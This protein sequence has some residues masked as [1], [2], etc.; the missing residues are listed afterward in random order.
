MAEQFINTFQN[1]MNSDYHVTLQPDGT[2]RFASNCQLIS[3]DGNNYVIKDTLGNVLT[4][5]INIRYGASQSL[6]DT[7]P[8]P[9][10]FI[11]LP[12]KLII[13]S[14]NNETAEGGCG[15]IGMIKYTTYGQGVMPI[16]EVGQMNSGYVP[17]YHSN[18]L[19]FSKLYRIEGFGIKENETI[20]RIYWT[21]NFNEPRTLNVLDPILSDYLPNTYTFDNNKTYMVLDGVIEFPI[22]SGDLYAPTNG[23]GTISGNIFGNNF[24]TGYTA[25]TGTSP[26]PKVILNIP[27]TLLSW[28]PDRLLSNIQISYN[29]VGNVYCGNKVYFYR[30]G[31]N[32]GYQTG[33]SY[34]SAP[35][36]V[37][38]NSQFSTGYAYHDYVG[39]GN[40]NELVSS[41]KS[42]FIKIDVIDTN[43]DYI[44]LACAEFDNNYGVMRAASIVDKKTITSDFPITL[45]HNGSTNLGNL[46]LNDL[47]LLPITLKTVKTLSTNKNFMLVGNIKEQDQ[48]TFDISGVTISSFNYPMPLMHNVTACAN[49]L[50]YNPQTPVFGNPTAGN[51]APN[52]RWLVTLGEATTNTVSYNGTLYLTGQV[53]T[54]INS[55]AGIN[56]QNTITFAGT[57][58]VQP[59]VTKNRYTPIGTSQ[60]REN[61]IPLIGDTLFWDYKSATVEYYLMI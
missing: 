19:K 23:T 13:F 54:G 10:G 31:L 2:Y 12:D 58:S 22:S 38:T 61:A 49:T 45:Q 25:I 27:V 29:S 32:S 8:M 57:G 33:W 59:C 41:G 11:S 4:F 55:G 20:E 17:L 43:Y 48:L 9:I 16:S 37:G 53:I 56:A 35:V 42:V 34:P 14:T 52:S 6:F 3:Q 28:S 7:P 26:T 51:V 50:V 21:D 5:V 47:T 44:E 36:H 18:D 46:T 40:S 30:Y 15:E 39:A 60:R 24:S 1:G